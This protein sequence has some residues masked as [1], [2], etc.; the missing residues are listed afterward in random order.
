MYK[1]MLIDDSPI[2]LDVMEAIINT[3][4]EYNLELHKFLKPEKALDNFQ[5]IS[6]DLVI[7]DIDMPNIDG[8]ELITCIKSLTNTP[9]L[10]VSGST[11][12]NNSTD[13]LLYCAKSIGAEFILNKDLIKEKLSSVV[14]AILTS[15]NKS[16][17]VV[18]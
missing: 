14:T 10:V 3:E 17:S 9:V 16:E 12:S 1:V 6:P 5:E 4:I 18:E 13:T 8:F 7:T 2:L 11:V 15:T